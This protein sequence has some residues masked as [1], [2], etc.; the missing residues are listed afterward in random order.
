MICA[1]YSSFKSCME[2]ATSFATLHDPYVLHVHFSNPLLFSLTI[3]F[4]ALTITDI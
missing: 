1:R 2:S 3:A 4:V